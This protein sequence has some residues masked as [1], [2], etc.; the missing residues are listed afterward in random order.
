MF[1]KILYKYKNSGERTMKEW[2]HHF[3]I[4]INVL[5]YRWNKGVRGDEL[6]DPVTSKYNYTQYVTYDTGN[7]D[8]TMTLKE[9]AREFGV[10]P[11]TLAQRYANGD[12]GDHLFRQIRR[13]RQ[14]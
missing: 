1:S 9:W 12:R 14:K 11:N 6:F 13:K 10:S 8:E 4:D 2:A 7:G 3:N 5:R